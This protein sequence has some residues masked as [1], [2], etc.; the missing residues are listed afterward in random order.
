[1]RDDFSHE[2]NLIITINGEKVQ[3]S[4]CSHVGIVNIQNA[5]E[6]L[7]LDKLSTIIGGFHLYNP[8]NYKYESDAVIDSVANVL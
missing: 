8:P 4:G 1:V 7:L 2:Q 6:Q 3:I 5:A